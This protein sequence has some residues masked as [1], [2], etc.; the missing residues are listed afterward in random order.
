MPRRSP[1]SVKNADGDVNAENVKTTINPFQQYPQT[2][3]MPAKLGQRRVPVSPHVTS[4]M[5]SFFFLQ[6]EPLARWVGE[7]RPKLNRMLIKGAIVT[8]SV[9]HTCI[10]YPDD[11]SPPK[12]QV[13]TRGKADQQLSPRVF[14]RF[15]DGV[16]LFGR[17][18]PWPKSSSS[19]P[20]RRPRYQQS[21]QN[22]T[23][24]AVAR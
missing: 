10:I 24:R 9:V 5:L 6:R 1:C 23:P 14:A 11:G 8:R 13:I 19:M 20:P 15:V 4:R 2:P 18:R 17:R 3:T 21:Q 22:A 7:N 16:D 12:L